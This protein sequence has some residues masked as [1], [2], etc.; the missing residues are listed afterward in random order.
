MK[1]LCICLLLLCTVAGSTTFQR[2][3]EIG[4][5]IGVAEVPGGYVLAAASG[6]TCTLRGLDSEGDNIWANIS[7]FW[8]GA[9]EAMTPLSDGGFLV[10][11]SR[12]YAGRTCASILK[13]S[14]LGSYV[15]ETIIS[16]P[17]SGFGLGCTEGPDGTLA[18][19]GTAYGPEWPE[20]EGFIATLSAGG[21]LL[22]I[23]VYDF[24][25]GASSLVSICAQP[26]S[27]F[28]VCGFSSSVASWAARVD[29][30]RS[31]IWSHIWVQG[32]NWSTPTCCIP[33]DDFGMVQCGYAPLDNWTQVGFADLFDDM[34]DTVWHRIYSTSLY[35]ALHA[36]SI[37]EIDTGGYCV[38]GGEFGDAILI[39]T[40]AVGNEIWRT[41]YQCAFEGSDVRYCSD[42]GFVISASTFSGDS[43][44][45]I[46][47][48][49][50]G[51][52]DLTGIAP[53]GSSGG[54]GELSIAASPNP[55]SGEV[56]V[57]FSPGWADADVTVFDQAG[58]IVVGQ[59]V[60]G[61]ISTGQTVLID[62]PE[63]TPAGVYIVLARTAGASARSRLVLVPR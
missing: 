29:D 7:V 36:Y 20:G 57:T 55:S 34:G 45:L 48:D 3:Y 19:C 40:D 15:L 9:A 27:G 51:Y 31:V 35:Q 37:D 47:T 32:L 1:E 22:G 24:D 25:D 50:S 49:G 33:A 52:V 18:V 8:G 44:W 41:S 4:S 5:P 60:P 46:K 12:E 30:D 63:D 59:Q 38:T 42:G 2:S 61:R 53:D 28:A 54:G 56:F 43:T 10:V 58:R 11:G 6:E 62:L 26:D 23:D 14:S 17:D 13:I 16:L 39:R 21:L